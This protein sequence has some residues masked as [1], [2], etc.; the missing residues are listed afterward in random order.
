LAELK[1]AVVPVGRVDA[2]EVEA[3][4]RELSKVLHRPIELRE[5]APL[6]RGTEDSARGQHRAGPL[7][8]ELRSAL[9]RLAVRKLVG[10]ATAASP[11]ATPSP[12]AVLFVTDV[13]LFTPTTESVLHELDSARRAA[14]LS[15]RRL[16][17]AFY[18]RKA[19]PPRQKGRLVKQ[20][21]YAVGRLQGLPEC[22]DSSCAL[23]PTLSLVDLDRKAEKFCAPCWRRLSAGIV[24]I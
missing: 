15:V 4:C 14:L 17:E 3:A 20:M 6:P 2:D 16:R 11:V 10:G 13:D 18:R 7:L 12:D 5:A 19:D 21:L 22:S 24:R 8:A 1:I 23:A 9:P